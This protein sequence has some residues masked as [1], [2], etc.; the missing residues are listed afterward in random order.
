[1]TLVRRRVSPK[2]RSIEV[3]VPDAVLVLGG[4]PQVGGQPLAVG[5]QAFHRRGVGRRVLGGHLGDA[6]VDQLDEPRAGLGLEVFGVEQ[7][8]V[9][10]LDL[11]LHPG[12]DL[13]QDV[14]RA[15]EA[16]KK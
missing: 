14:S 11:G 6:R 9:G 8:P 4:E 12:R 3:G 13:G 7:G 16:V 1:M 10:V 15:I 5:E 2:V